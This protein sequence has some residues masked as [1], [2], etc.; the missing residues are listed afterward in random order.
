MRITMKYILLILL[1]FIS[2]SKVSAEAISRPINVETTIDTSQFISYQITHFSI[3]PSHL[4]LVYLN[5]NSSFRDERVVASVSTDA[6]STDDAVQLKL[7]AINLKSDCYDYDKNSIATTS[8]FVSIFLNDSGDNRQ[9]V[10]LNTAVDI[11]TNVNSDDFK[12]SDF[13][14]WFV[15]GAIPDKAA[16]CDGSVSFSVEIAI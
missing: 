11:P 5:N 8:D 15:F 3:M 9:Q 2:I 16:S 13:N 6:P 1:L 10:N 14:L 7:K 4:N 12:G